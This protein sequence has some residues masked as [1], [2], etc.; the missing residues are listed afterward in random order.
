MQIDANDRTTGPQH[1]RRG[2]RT[3]C[4]VVNLS[5]N[6]SCAALRERLAE[7]LGRELPMGYTAWKPHPVAA[8]ASGQ[9]PSHRHV[10]L[11]KK[12]LLEPVPPNPPN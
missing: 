3:R 7:K 2:L 4:K 9:Q 8:T 12:N 6:G 1:L 10:P 11:Y 5:Q